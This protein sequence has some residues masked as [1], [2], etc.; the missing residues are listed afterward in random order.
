[1]NWRFW[2]PR[3]TVT[4]VAR[5]LAVGLQDESLVLDEPFAD[6]GD[7]GLVVHLAVPSAC[8]DAEVLEKVKTL[9]LVADE[10]HRHG[11]GHGL[12]LLGLWMSAA[13]AEQAGSRAVHV[14]LKPRVQADRPELLRDVVTILRQRSDL[15]LAADTGA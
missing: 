6:E 8:S 10:G 13:Q 9:T 11:G 7:D 3:H 15:P 2:E 14:N 1:M 5:R 4:S 12:S